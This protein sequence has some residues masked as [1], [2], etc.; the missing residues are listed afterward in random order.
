MDAST[1][2]GIGGAG[3]HY[4]LLK[5]EDLIPIFQMYQKCPHKKAFDLPPIAY[6]ELIAALV[7]FS[8]FSELYQNTLVRLNTDNSDVVSWLKRGRCS[9]GLGFKILATIEYFKRKNGL[10]ISTF[11]ILGRHNNTA[12]M[13]SRGKIPRWL[14]N[15]G[16][17]L[18]IDITKLHSIISNPLFFWKE[19]LMQSFV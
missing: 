19:N 7:G 14:I 18:E 17:R 9:R 12:D 10:K 16:K 4:F 5:H 6:I 13:L 15:Q 2:W 3:T 8:V 11:H 1:D